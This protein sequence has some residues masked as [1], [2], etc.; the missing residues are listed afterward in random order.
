[1]FFLNHF[2]SF[3]Y[4]DREDIPTCAFEFIDVVI[5][6]T[7]TT[8]KDL[9]PIVVAINNFT[10]RLE[11]NQLVLAYKMLKAHIKKIE[12]TVLSLRCDQA[13]INEFR[14][15]V[16]QHIRTKR[17]TQ[18]RIRECVDESLRKELTDLQKEST[19][20][21]VIPS[22]WKFNPDK[23][24]DQQKDKM[25]ER[26]T[27]IP[28]LYNDS[29]QSQESRSIKPWTPHKLVIPHADDH[30]SMVIEVNKTP[31]ADKVKSAPFPPEQCTEINCDSETDCAPET[32]TEMQP[33]IQPETVNNQMKVLEID[34]PTSSE[35]ESIIGV[36]TNNVVKSHASDHSNDLNHTIDKNLKN[37]E[38]TKRQEDIINL[39]TP[40]NTFQT[41]QHVSKQFSPEE[42]EEKRKQKLLAA[43][44]KI[45][46]NIVDAD[47]F[48]EAKQTRTRNLKRQTNQ[49]PP[50]QRKRQR[51]SDVSTPKTTRRS[52]KTRRK[53]IAAP[54]MTEKTT[55]KSSAR[56]L[57][58]TVDK[59]ECLLVPMEI[60][61]EKLR[62]TIDEQLSTS[63]AS[64]GKKKKNLVNK[65]EVVV[66]T[67][68]TIPLVIKI[69]EVTFLF[70]CLLINIAFCTILIIEFMISNY[71]HIFFYPIRNLSMMQISLKKK[72]IYLNHLILYSMA[73]FQFHPL[74][75]N[76]QI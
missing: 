62:K 29:S 12:N 7:A 26:R 54:Q 23:L 61:K 2:F 53:S 16:T 66:T 17:A 5:Q 34:T 51:A 70:Y 20:F 64:K 47:D 44:K 18:L 33:Q 52:I 67:P 50:G 46:I 49:S 24:T 39:D 56:N 38:L 22:V 13:L 36:Q 41:H 75:R 74:P 55:S 25:K 6:T 40:P 19:T 58:N 31:N 8:I 48:T 1:M 60:P 32:D 65:E 28:A 69:K 57:S 72:P 37:T 27:D 63:A 59:D 9:N 71:T 35:V 15:I 43:L 45:E 30:E 68:D 14:S 11:G 3:Y 4:L 42:L 76:N 73:S 21:V 10:K